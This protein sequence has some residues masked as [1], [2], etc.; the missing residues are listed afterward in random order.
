MSLECR[1]REETNMNYLKK[2]THNDKVLWLTL[3]RPEIH[4]AF[5]DELIEQLTTE[6]AALQDDEETRLVILA[7]EGKSFC[8]GADLNWMKK[9]K[10]YSEEE[11]Y[12]DSLKLQGLFQAI[13]DCPVPVMARVNGA[14]LG[15]GTGLISACDYVLSV[16]SA[17]FGF[18]EVSLGLVPAVISPFVIAKIGQ[19]QARAYFMSGERF[20]GQ[21]AYDMGLVHQLCEEE[22]LDEKIERQIK[23]FLS[24]GPIAS[25]VS[26]HL[27]GGVIKRRRSS[28]SAGIRDF[29]CKV[30]SKLRTS[31]EGQEGMSAL[32]EK[33]KPN[34]IKE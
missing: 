1:L 24:A 28:D 26:K 23:F 18:T 25:Q 3:N 29:T 20:K 11:N 22:E 31:E 32:L 15:G 8:A 34:W 16:K 27:I 9:M 5:N 7:G 17:S 12:Q 10:D 13:N 4:N 33:R 21:R 6:F 2:K 19:S 30:I 14:C